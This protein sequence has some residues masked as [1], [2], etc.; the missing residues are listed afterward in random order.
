MALDELPGEFETSNKKTIKSSSPAHWQLS[1]LK[2]CFGRLCYISVV[3]DFLKS[4]MFQYR[5]HQLRR[6][7][8]PSF[9]ALN[10]FC[11]LLLLLLWF[12]GKIIVT[13]QIGLWKKYIC[14]PFRIICGPTSCII[15]NTY[16]FSF[17]TWF[18][19][20]IYSVLG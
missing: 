6:W 1:I 13:W 12:V 2:N 8:D 4:S 17:L 11:G 10:A 9:R 14:T 18:L 7:E 15:M 5:L 3:R 19:M 20:R 16:R